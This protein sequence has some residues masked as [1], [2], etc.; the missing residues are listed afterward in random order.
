MIRE[1][2]MIINGITF[3]KRYSDVGFYILQNETGVKYGEAIDIITAPYTYT[4]TDEIIPVEQE[5]EEQ[6]ETEEEL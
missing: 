1:E 2:E 6:I 4:E 3:I 5:E